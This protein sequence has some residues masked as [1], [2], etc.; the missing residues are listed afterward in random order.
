MSNWYLSFCPTHSQVMDELKDTG[1]CICQTHSVAKAKQHLVERIEG[2][3]LN[4]WLTP[5]SGHHPMS[6]RRQR[7]LSHLQRQVPNAKGGRN[8]K[9]MNPTYKPRHWLDYPQRKRERT[10][11]FFIS[12]LGKAGIHK[13]LQFQMTTFYSWGRGASSVGKV[14]DMQAWWIQFDPQ[15]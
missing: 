7:K 9:W 10:S 5:N 2:P 13:R 12:I 3:D 11:Y 8:L 14:L 15:T 6:P 1:I 4:S